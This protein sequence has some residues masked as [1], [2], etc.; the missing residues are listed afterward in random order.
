MRYK[1][2]AAFVTAL[3]IL[4]IAGCGSTNQQSPAAPQNAALQAIAAQCQPDFPF[5]I[6]RTTATITSGQTVFVGFSMHSLCGLAGTINVGVRGISPPPTATCSK[7]HGGVCTSNGPTISQCCYDFWL[8]ANGSAG[9][10]ITFGATPATLKTT[11]IITLQGED[12]TGG[13]CY[14]RTHSVTFALT[15]N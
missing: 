15:V 1:A 7:G 13:C 8:P 11:Y 5:G 14:G 2:L 10:H 3:G 4:V 6:S 9:N 12:I